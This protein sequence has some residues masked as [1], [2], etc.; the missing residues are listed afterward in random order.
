MTRNKQLAWS[1][2]FTVR[3]QDRIDR[4][5]MASSLKNTKREQESFAYIF[6]ISHF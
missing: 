1:Y 3:Q 6:V 5:I 2:K 4:P